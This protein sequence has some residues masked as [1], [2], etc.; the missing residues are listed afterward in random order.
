MVFIELHNFFKIGQNKHDPN[1]LLQGVYIGFL[2][3]QINSLCLF[4]QCDF[5]YIK[6]HFIFRAVFLFH[7]FWTTQIEFVFTDQT[8]MIEWRSVC[9]LICSKIILIVKTRLL[10]R[11]CNTF[12][13][14]HSPRLIIAIIF[15]FFE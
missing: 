4:I 13:L 7:L 2:W 14:S 12:V 10:L 3:C 1:G 6:K 15:F 9:F 5:L 11:V 8:F